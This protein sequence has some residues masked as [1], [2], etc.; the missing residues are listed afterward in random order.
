MSSKRFFIC[1]AC[2]RPSFAANTNSG[3]ESL[4]CFWCKST[5]R[6]RAIILEIH[7]CYLLMKVRE[8]FRDV[9]IL[10]VSDGY[11]TSTVLKKVY[12]KQYENYHY[13]LDPKLDI[14]E[15]PAHLKGCADI[16][17]CSEVLEHVEPPIQKAFLG[18]YQLLRENGKLVLSVPHTDANGKHVEHFPIMTESRILSRESGLVLEGKGIDGELFEFSNLAFHGGIGATLEYRIFSK[19]SLKQNLEIAGFKSLK[20]CK[21]NIFYGVNWEPWSRVWTCQKSK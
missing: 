2:F 7:K 8:P 12:R 5:A 4:N 6:E 11:L 19:N 10:G 16:I 3:R 1:S 18:L 9:K 15:V 13:H 21:N 14:T 20:S 17:S